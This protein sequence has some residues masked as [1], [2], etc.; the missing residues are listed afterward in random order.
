[1]PHQT[2]LCKNF[3]DSCTPIDRCIC[4]AE[5]DATDGS[6]QVHLHTVM[7]SLFPTIPETAGQSLL[8]IG[9][10][11]RDLHKMR[12]CCCPSSPSYLLLSLPLPQAGGQSMPPVTCSMTLCSRLVPRDIH[13]VFGC[14]HISV[15]HGMVLTSHRYSAFTQACWQHM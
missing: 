4:I 12:C 13:T 2:L 9:I 14:R 1:M 6:K 10:D 15:H 11:M 8:D 7:R 5:P 3:R